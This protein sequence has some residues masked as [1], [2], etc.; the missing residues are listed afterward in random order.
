M[1]EIV[2]GLLGQLSHKPGLME[3]DKEADSVLVLCTGIE[4]M[5]RYL[6]SH[7]T[8]LCETSYKRVL[9]EWTIY[10]LPVEAVD[11]KYSIVY[12]YL[13]V[14]II[15]IIIELCVRTTCYTNYT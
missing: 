11:T 12:Y 4:I 14:A 10:L 2:S 1:H 6:R 5:L 15:D 9:E 8:K 3:E 7:F 13:K